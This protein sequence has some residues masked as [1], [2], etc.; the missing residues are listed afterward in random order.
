MRE[1]AGYSG[2]MRVGY[3]YWVHLIAQHPK[4]NLIVLHST[5][6]HEEEG[7]RKSLMPSL[8]VDYTELGKYRR[9]E[10]KV[11]LAIQVLKSQIRVRFCL[12]ASPI[13]LE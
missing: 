5:P 13:T 2:N 1:A 11:A 12:V 4:R 7:K 8:G 6:I 3:K 9:G 10:E